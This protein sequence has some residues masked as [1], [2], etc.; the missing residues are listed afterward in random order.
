M[1][2]KMENTDLTGEPTVD[3]FN[4]TDEVESA[5]VQEA[6][7]EAGIRFI[8]RADMGDDPLGIID[9]DHGEGIIAVLEDDADRAMEVIQSVLPDET[10]IEEYEDEDDF[11]DEEDD[12]EEDEES[13]EDGPA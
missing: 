12:L 9:G 10:E 4:C 2:D 1:A 3:I 5:L 11:E 6:L 8:L 7:N 13:E